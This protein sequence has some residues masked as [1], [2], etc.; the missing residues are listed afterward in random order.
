VSGDAERVRRDALNHHDQMLDAQAGCVPCKLCGGKAVIT[1]A[2]TGAGYYIQ[3]DNSLSFRDYN[4]CLLDER[5]LSGWAYNVMDWWNR[6]HAVSAP[7]ARTYAEGMEDS[8]DLALKHAAPNDFPQSDYDE[9][10]RDIAVAIRL[11]SRGEKA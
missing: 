7:P 9:A 1:D 6:L 3:C 8:A 11:L 5:R 2:G 4:G 10:C